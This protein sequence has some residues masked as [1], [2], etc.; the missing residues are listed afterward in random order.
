MQVRT[1]KTKAMFASSYQHLLKS[2]LIAKYSDVSELTEFIQSEIVHPMREPTT[3]HNNHM[4]IKYDTYTK[5]CTQHDIY[6]D[7]CIVY[8]KY[9]KHLICSQNMPQHQHWWSHV[10]HY[11]PR[12]KPVRVRPR[13]VS[14]HSA[15]FRADTKPFF[16]FP[17]MY[18]PQRASERIPQTD[19]N[20]TIFGYCWLYNDFAI[21]HTHYMQTPTTTDASEHVPDLFCKF[22]LIWKSKENGV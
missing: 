6:T 1:R 17:E 5:E 22:F 19:E 10:F 2:W 11:S 21:S 20:A 8:A 18:S 16:V 15:Q 3:L 13:N 7:K 4:R 14:V 12:Q 9:C